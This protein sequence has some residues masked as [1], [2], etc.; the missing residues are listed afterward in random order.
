MLKFTVELTRITVNGSLCIR[1]TVRDG[2]PGV[3]LTRCCLCYDNQLERIPGD[4]WWCCDSL[5]INDFREI[6]YLVPAST[7]VFI[8]FSSRFSVLGLS[9]T[10]VLLS[11]AESWLPTH[12]F[13][14]HL[15]CHVYF[16]LKT[17][18]VFSFLAPSWSYV[19]LLLHL[20][21][22]LLTVPTWSAC[23]L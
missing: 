14:F 3:W 2:P 13:L 7:A 15:S 10:V 18:Y 5:Q 11:A 1:S 21:N 9:G 12:V 19:L 20:S 22:S 6:V 16:L 17:C 23:L 8:I 4:T